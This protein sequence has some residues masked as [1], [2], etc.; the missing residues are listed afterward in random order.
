LFSTTKKT[1]DLSF[2]CIG[3]ALMLK[4]I[5]GNTKDVMPC[6]GGGT[7]GSTHHNGTKALL[8]QDSQNIFSNHLLIQIFF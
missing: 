1:F 4:N 8:V 2:G 6:V 5:I 7:L 3:F